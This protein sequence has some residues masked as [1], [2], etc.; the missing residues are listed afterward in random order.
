SGEKGA[1]ALPSQTCG[2]R[3]PHPASL[4]LG[5]LRVPPN[6]TGLTLL[7]FVAP[8][9]Y[10]RLLKLRDSYYSRKRFLDHVDNDCFDRRT[11]RFHLLFFFPHSFLRCHTFWLGPGHCRLSRFSSRRLGHR[12]CLNAHSRAS[13]ARFWSLFRLLLC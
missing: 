11:W 5:S 8:R 12:A 10:L 7:P 9:R 3:S 13:S 6:E 4:T 1:R 2:L